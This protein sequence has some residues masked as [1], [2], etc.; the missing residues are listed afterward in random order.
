MECYQRERSGH[1][2]DQCRAVFYP[3]AA[4]HVNKIL[5]RPDLGPVDVAADYPV[6]ADLAAEL[7]HRFLVIRHVFDRGLGFELDVGRERPIAETETAP[8]SIHPD[9]QV[10]NAIVKRGADAI[11]QPIEVRQAVEL[12]AV[13]DEVTLAVGGGVND[14]FREAHGAEADAEEF[15]EELVMVARDERHPRLLAVLAEQFLDE[16]I[17]FFRP[18]PFPAQLP[19]VDEIADDVKVLA[20]VVTEEGE[21]FV[22]LGML[23][24]EVNVRDPDGAI[25]HEKISNANKKSARAGELSTEKPF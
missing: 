9:V 5:D 18:V 23:R 6:H 25:V 16:Q 8:E 2:F 17:V 12:M 14:A 7:D 4:V 22:H 19:A 3:I 15:F 24:A 21:E 13:N 11:E 1:V 10:E 20:L